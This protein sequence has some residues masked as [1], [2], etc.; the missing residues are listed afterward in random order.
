MKYDFDHVI[1]RKNTSCIKW[2]GVKAVF[3]TSDAIPMWIAD[4]DM[5]IA[6]PITD[7]IKERMKHNIFGYP[8]HNPK[9][10]V[11][12]V[13]Y[14]MHKLYS[15]EIKPE[16]IILT[17]GII[18]ALYASVRAFS[19]PGDDIILQGPVYHPF[20]SAIKDN[21]CHISENR[22]LLNDDHYEINFD[23]LNTKFE[24]R[25]GR[26]PTP[27]RARLLILCSPHNPVGR[28]WTKYELTKIGE[29]TTRN[30]AIIVSDE[31]H[32]ELLFPNVNHVPIV[33]GGVKML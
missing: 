27:S 29:I 33:S 14:R 7:A 24:K 25:D 8:L 13:M 3:G 15:W 31:V 19:R 18:P 17:P 16:W 28:V 21:G 26:P 10:V 2:D 5:P 30:G 11:E 20:W 22:L 12:S 4:M 23:D 9:S 1:S 6:K 32:S